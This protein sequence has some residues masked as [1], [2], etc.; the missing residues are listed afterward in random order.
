MINLTVRS[1]SHE[2]HGS[3]AGLVSHLGFDDGRRATQGGRAHTAQ[4]TDSYNRWTDRSIHL[5]SNIDGSFEAIKG[6]RWVSLLH[7]P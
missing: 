7:L 4:Q 6:S 1:A 3:L 5:A 2:F